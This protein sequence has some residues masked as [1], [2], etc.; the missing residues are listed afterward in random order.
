MFYF[1]TESCVYV[2]L[3]EPI[4]KLHCLFSKWDI[5]HLTEWR[6]VAT[7]GHTGSSAFGHQV[8]CPE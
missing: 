7:H 1:H 5:N 3:K 4:S 6:T 8:P 2:K